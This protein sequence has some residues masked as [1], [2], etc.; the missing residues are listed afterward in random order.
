VSHNVPFVSGVL[1][2]L[3][4]SCRTTDSVR[5][6]Q[7]PLIETFRIICRICTSLAEDLEVQDITTAI[8]QG[9]AAKI[10]KLHLNQHFPTCTLCGRLTLL[11]S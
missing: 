6:G 2:K 8:Q 7:K 10:T 4:I 11:A 9:S 3:L 5:A 1:H